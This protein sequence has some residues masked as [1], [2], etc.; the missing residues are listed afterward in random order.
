VTLPGGG[1]VSFQYDPFG[2]RI[3]KVSASGTSVYVYD[4]DNQI[5]ELNS[6]GG[7]VARYTQGLGI[8]EPIA[9]YRSGKKYYYHADGLGSVVA[10]T[11]NHGTTK[12]SYTYDAF[13]NYVQPEPPPPPSS[14]TNPFRYTGREL[15]SET[16]LYYYRARYYDSTIGRFLSEDP[17]GFDGG[18][19]LYAYVSNSPVNSLDPLGLV[20]VNDRIRRV[21]MIDVD[22]TCRP[23]TGGACTVKV[24][25]VLLCRCEC[26]A[27]G[28]KLKSE[29]RIF[30]DLYYTNN[31]INIRKR[32]P[33]DKTV[34]DPRSAIAH[35]YDVHINPAIAAVKQVVEPFEAKTFESKQKCGDACDSLSKSIPLLFG[36][37]LVETQTQEE[38]PGWTRAR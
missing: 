38:K 24:A 7:V 9:L 27:G 17:I 4:G 30:G 34:V 32:N 1:V 36:N 13:G 18:S 35:E 2:R 20:E 6:S 29:L 11:D 25:S 16:G 28:W 33:K 23:G 3:E 12:A 26:E 19:N 21:P 10:L 5:E 15:D 14:V 22:Q 31:V 37:T 8:D